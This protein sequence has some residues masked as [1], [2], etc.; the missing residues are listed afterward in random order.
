MLPIFSRLSLISQLLWPSLHLKENAIDPNRR[1]VSCFS[2]SLILLS[3][4]KSPALTTWLLTSKI[5][6]SMETYLCLKA[7]LLLLGRRIRRSDVVDMYMVERICCYGHHIA[8]RRWYG[9]S[10]QNIPSLMV[11]LVKFAFTILK[12]TYNH[13]QLFHK[14]YTIC[15]L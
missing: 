8:S 13:L 6:T 2:S 3:Q 1:G 12:S 5:F 15:A 9:E 14:S 4:G 11:C 10:N 7:Y